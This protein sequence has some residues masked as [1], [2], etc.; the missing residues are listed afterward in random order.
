M[1]KKPTV[2]TDK[3]LCANVQIESI[4]YMRATALGD[5]LYINAMFDFSREK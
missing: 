1:R 2:L 3:R 5:R 4:F